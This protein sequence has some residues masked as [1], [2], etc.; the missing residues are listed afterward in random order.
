MK[1]AYKNL[2][3]WASADKLAR[4]VYQETKVFPKSEQFGL[5]SQLRR[6]SVSVVLNIIE[7]YARRSDGDFRRFFI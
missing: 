3:M 7:G 6:A 2:Q 4:L 1:K 5:T